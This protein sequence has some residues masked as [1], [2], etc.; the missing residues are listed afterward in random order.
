M[1]GA[2]EPL[3]GEGQMETRP[4]A[5]EETVTRRVEGVGRSSGGRTNRPSVLRAVRAAEAKA[6]VFPI[7]LPAPS[8]GLVLSG[9]VVLGGPVGAFEVQP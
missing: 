1:F 5:L 2:P 9:T 7:A 3:G 6:V 4:H 8:L